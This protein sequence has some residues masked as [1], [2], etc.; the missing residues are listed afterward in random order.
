V[1][2]C[3]SSRKWRP[4]AYALAYVFSIA[5]AAMEKDKREAFV[6]FYDGLTEQNIS[7]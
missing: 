2:Q 4:G 6:L 3:E 5:V 7:I 1:N